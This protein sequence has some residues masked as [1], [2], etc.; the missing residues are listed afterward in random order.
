MTTVVLAAALACLALFCD[1]ARGSIVFYSQF[2]PASCPAESLVYFEEMTGQR[3]DGPGCHNSTVVGSNRPTF[4]YKFVNGTH[5]GTDYNSFWAL[6]AH[7]SVS[8]YSSE[9]CDVTP[10]TRIRALLGK[11]YPDTSFFAA[12]GTTDGYVCEHTNSLRFF[13]SLDSHLFSSFVFFCAPM[14]STDSVCRQK[15]V[16]MRLL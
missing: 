8:Q 13:S 2:G 6:K 4:M 1:S 15:G 10:N 5:A 7:I 3:D 11:G 14:G 16:Q 12:R 9:S